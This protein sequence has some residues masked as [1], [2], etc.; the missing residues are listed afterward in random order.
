MDRRHFILHAIS[1]GAVAAIAGSAQAQSV[2]RTRPERAYRD[3]LLTG[4]ER[5]R[6]QLD[7]RNARTDRERAQ[8]RDTYRGI[9]D[10]RAPIVPNQNVQPYRA[11]AGGWPGS[12]TGAQPPSEI[13]VPGAPVPGMPQTQGTPVR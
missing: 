1:T 2:P 7:M 13:G 3:D 8:I 12:P 4:E 11:P 10:Q 6:F 5:G 9:V